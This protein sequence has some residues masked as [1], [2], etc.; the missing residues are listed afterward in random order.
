MKIKLVLTVL[1][2]VA[3]FSCKKGKRNSE[4]CN[5]DTRREIKVLIDA[6][7]GNINFISDTSTVTA[8]GELSVPEVKS[9]TGRQNVELQVYTV[10][11]KVDKCDKKWDGD[12]H[13]RLVENDNYL[14]T[15]CPNPGCSYAQLS[16]YLSQYKNVRDF[17]EKNDL[18][19][20][21]VT[22]T[23]VA[24]VDID[25]K[26]KRK[27]AKNNLELHPILDIRF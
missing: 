4:A 11:A 5:G 10:T 6:N 19:G 15:E 18:E 12:Y 25:H 26:Y 9:S 23:G 16:N 22:I 27:Q 20:K 24:F 8:L 3:M 2:A 7:V 21:T 17:I 14:I 1:F 13:I